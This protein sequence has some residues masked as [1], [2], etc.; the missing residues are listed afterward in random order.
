MLNDLHMIYKLEP[1]KEQKNTPESSASEELKG[2]NNDF[3][4]PK[5]VLPVLNQDL[6][7]LPYEEDEAELLDDETD[8]ESSAGLKVHRV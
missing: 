8:F 4:P 2:N 6:N 3:Q 5:K 1:K 7:C